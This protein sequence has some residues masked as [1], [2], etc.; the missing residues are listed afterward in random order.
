MTNDGRRSMLIGHLRDSSFAI[1]CL[2]H[3]FEYRFMP[4]LVG[5]GEN[6]K[7]DRKIDRQCLK[8]DNSRLFTNYY[9]RML[10]VYT[11]TLHCMLY[12]ILLGI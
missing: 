9:I 3:S 4:S 6:V 1:N 11:L 5:S 7:D 2:G 8:K 12:W 10:L